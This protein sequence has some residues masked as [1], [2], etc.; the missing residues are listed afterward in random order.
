[1]VSIIDNPQPEIINIGVGLC[2]PL[3]GTFYYP[4]PFDDAKFI[5]VV[6]DQPKVEI[7]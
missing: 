4:P 1:M 3:M 2:P 6:P 5:S 7:F